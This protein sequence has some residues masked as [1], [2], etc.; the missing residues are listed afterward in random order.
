[1]LRGTFGYE[2]FRPGRKK[3]INAVLAGGTASAF[4]PRAGEILTFQ[5]PAK[6][7]GGTVLVISPLISPRERPGGRVDSI[8]FPGGGH[9]F[10]AQG[11]GTARADGGLRR[12]DFELVYVAPEALEEGFRQF[13]AACP[14]R[15]LVVD[16]AHCISHWGHEFR[17]SYRNLRGL[18]ALLGNVPV[19]ALTAT[20]TPGGG[21]GHPS[22]IEHGQTGRV[23]G[24]F[25]RPNLRITCQKKG[26]GRDTKKDLCVLFRGAPASAA[27]FIG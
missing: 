12:G 22:T 19:L 11:G 26:G 5:I 6:L 25:F 13:L 2:S 18:K 8:G 14:V 7:L 1:M 16:E 23:Q 27:L 3:I 4:C 24:V 9:Q 21:P 15:L 17:P 20:A 10:H